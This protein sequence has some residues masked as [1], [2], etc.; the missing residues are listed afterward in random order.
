MMKNIKNLKKILQFMTL[1]IFSLQ[2]MF[3]IEK[4]LAGPTMVSGGRK[5]ISTLTKPI[6]ISICKMGQFDYAHS[7][8]LGYSGSTKYLTGEHNNKSV[9]S[10]TGTDGNLTFK[11]ALTYLFQSNAE[12]KDLYS[13]VNTTSQFLLPFGLCTVAEGLPRKLLIKDRNRFTFYIKED[14][15]YVVFVSDPA[16]TLPYLLPNPLTTGESM[17]IG[18]H[19]N[20]VTK[21]T[22]YYSVELTERQVK[23]GDKS[24]INYPDQAGHAS[25]AD[26]VEDENQRRI[27]PVLGCMVPWMSRKNQCTQ[28]IQRLPKQKVF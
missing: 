12:N 28:P 10:W 22:E 20:S 3:V 8:H 19:P 15:E 21:R 16:A 27:L 5:T 26:C 23:S 9:L 13:D 18:I 4:Y 11:D 6:L 25:Y 14:G 7:L 24:C 1:I 17:K 2:M